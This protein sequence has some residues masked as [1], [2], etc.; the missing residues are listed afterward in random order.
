[1][2]DKPKDAVFDPRAE[3]TAP[4]APRVIEPDDG[5]TIGLLLRII[6]R[7]KWP[8]VLCLLAFPIAAVVA[9][10]RATPRYTASATVMFEAQQFSISELQSILREDTT[11]DAVVNSQIQIINSLSAADRV[12]QRLNLA[13]R[14]EFNPFERSAGPVARL[15]AGVRGLLADQL[16]VLAPD[17]ADA[18]RP[19]PDEPPTPEAVRNAVAGEVQ[20]RVRV[21]VVGRSRVLSIGF[22]SQD[23]ELAARAANLLGEFYI[24]DQLESK[25]DAV[26]RAN[27][28]LEERI[29]S[30][31][32]EVSEA[33]EKI[34]RFR[35]E[36]GL[37]QGQFGGLAAERVSR[38][39]SDLLQQRSEFALAEARQ[40]QAQAR[41]FDSLPQVQNNPA[42]LSL[43]S[44]EAQLRRDVAIQSAQLGDRHPDVVRARN[45]LA[46]NQ[47]LLGAEMGRVVAAVGTELSSAR[48]RVETTAAALA[49]AQRQ[50]SQAGADEVQ[51]RTLEREAE[52]ARTLLTA[53]LQRSQQTVSQ[54]AIEKADARVLSAAVPPGR[55]SWPRGNVILLGSIVLGGVIGLLVI[56][57]LEMNDRSIRTGED[58]RTDFGLPTLALV[59]EMK[60]RLGRGSSVEDYVV[61]KPMSAAAEAM[62]S[63]RAGL[64][65]GTTPPKCIAVTA[66]RPGEGKTTTAISLAR[67]ASLGGERVLVIDCDLRQPSFQRVFGPDD[68]QGIVDFLKGD[69]PFSAIRKRDRLTQLDYII[70]GQAEPNNGR[71]FMGEAMP[72]LIEQAKR[73]YD[74]VVLDAPP[75]LAMA[76]ARLIGRLADATLL[77]VRWRDTPRSVVRAALQ[78]LGEARAN[79]IGALL[80]RVDPRSHRSSGY[81]DAEV[82]HPRYG[83][84][85]RG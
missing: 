2:L 64:W 15:T 74:L 46:D 57:L 17:L 53:V 41:N 48:T 77:C 63:L 59:P 68:G 65:M 84:Y 1:M 75:A 67:V 56:Y 12:A 4:A 58:I 22:T 27:S 51:A 42:I 28:W 66:A 85:F 24:A 55:P 36:R 50:A 32:Q 61:Q 33:E 37:V 72:A 38:L 7:R 40:A 52:A 30:L 35:V 5:L 60:R 70:A 69:A 11:T 83:G 34:Q 23:A 25:F 80:T 6:R 10:N 3:R 45:A 14:A 73:D 20:D 62:R 79:V 26:R 18:L 82:Y 47:R 19:L 78:L 39:Q 16:Q 13:E 9:I 31:R 44:Q 71:L 81:A 21:E 29:G 43:R 8:L 49:E 54:T 76:D